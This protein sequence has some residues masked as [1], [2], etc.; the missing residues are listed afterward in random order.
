[1]SIREIYPRRY[2]YKLARVIV[3]MN[4]EHRY[5]YMNGVPLAKCLKYIYT[6]V[7]N[8]STCLWDAKTKKQLFS[9]LFREMAPKIQNQE[10]REQFKRYSD[11]QIIGPLYD[12]MAGQRAEEKKER[13][14]CFW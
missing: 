8:W 2:A 4:T 7:E 5:V 14:C 13:R 10:I 1:M 12:L 9:D 6:L 3:Y 11:D